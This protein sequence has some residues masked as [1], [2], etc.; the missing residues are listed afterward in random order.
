MDSEKYRAPVVCKNCGFSNYSN[1]PKGTQ[2]NEAPCPKCECKTLRQPNDVE[3]SRINYLPEN[4]GNRENKTN[5][6][7]SYDFGNIG[8]LGDVFGDIFRNYPPKK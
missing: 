8:D 4:R 3:L 2:I 7:I 6:G 5:S 1:F